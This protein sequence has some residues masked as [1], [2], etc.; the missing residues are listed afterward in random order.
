VRTRMGAAARRR[1]LESFTKEVFGARLVKIVDAV[2]ND[3]PKRA[4]ARN[5]RHEAGDT[6]PP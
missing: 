4:F 1:Y 5:N 2:A 3:D 6:A